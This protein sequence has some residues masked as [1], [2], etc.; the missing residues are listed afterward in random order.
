[1]TFKSISNGK[2]LVE[3]AQIFYFSKITNIIVYKISAKVYM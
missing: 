3:N 2:V 1:M